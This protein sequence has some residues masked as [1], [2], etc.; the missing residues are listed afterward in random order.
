MKSF[1][2]K[3]EGTLPEDGDP[4]DPPTREI[5]PSDQPAKSETPPMPRSK[6]ST[7]NAEVDFRGKRRLNAT[8]VSTT[9]PDARLYKN[10]RAPGPCFAS[11]VEEGQKTVRV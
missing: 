5:L 1:R 6:P 7:R 9:D 2:P 11:S 3:A 10:R 4:G 8:P